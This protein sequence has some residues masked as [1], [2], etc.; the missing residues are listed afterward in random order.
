MSSPT[1]NIKAPSRLHFG[2]FGGNNPSG[3]SFGGLGVMV[4]NPGIEVRIQP[5]PQRTF[6]GNLADRLETF[7]DYWLQFTGFHVQN[8]FHLDLVR[9]PQSHIGLGTGTQLGLCVGTLLFQYHMGQTP[10]LDHTAESTGRGQRS[11]VGSHGF[12]R[13][14]LIVDRGKSKG[15]T[16]GELEL[17]L[18]YPENWRFVLIQP[19]GIPGI[20]G[21]PENQY[22]SR[23]LAPL[24]QQRNRLI[25]LTKE[26]I[27]PAILQEDFP[28]FSQSVF[29]FGK[30]SG[31]YFSNIQGGPFN[32]DRITEI[33]EAGRREGIAGIGQSSW[34]PSIYVLA[35]SQ[36]H[37]EQIQEIF[38]P[39]LNPSESL[40]ISR[41]CNRGARLTDCHSFHRK[42][43]D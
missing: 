25:Q 40:I 7:T 8:E 4:E 23:K 42:F 22:F 12:L 20:S 24:T 3:N 33:I 30:L 32:G 6:T 38:A 36:H 1:L 35:Q 41:P 34:G 26:R 15:Q 10:S 5:A 27:I 39:M 43:N 21:S 31:S 16:L 29:E 18:A 13:G 2:L 9:A 11:S 28:E 14:G 17:Q 37:A 19:D